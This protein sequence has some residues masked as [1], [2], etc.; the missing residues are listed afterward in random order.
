MTI[1]DAQLIHQIAYHTSNKSPL[2]VAILKFSSKPA[3]GYG[4]L[5]P[6]S[7]PTQ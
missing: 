4:K 7:Y 6:S 2:E 5:G 1:S 3:I